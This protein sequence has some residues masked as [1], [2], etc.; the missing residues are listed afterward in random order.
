MRHRRVANF[1][2]EM[3]ELQEDLANSESDFYDKLERLNQ[4]VKQWEDHGA[5]ELE[6]YPQYIRKLSALLNYCLGEVKE[7]ERVVRWQ[8]ELLQKRGRY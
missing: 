8:N 4:V 6:D 5:Y 1:E 3:R 7:M 2:E